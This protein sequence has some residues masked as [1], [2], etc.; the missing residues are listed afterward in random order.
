M[1]TEEHDRE[2]RQVFGDDAEQYDTAR[3]GY[4]DRL[5][6]DVLDFA[7]LPA[8]VPAVEVGAGTGKATLAFAARG[9]PV[10]CVEPDARM[11]RV[12]RSR[13]TG[14][15][16]VAV[17]VADFETWRPDRAYGLL[18]CAQAW[19][20]VDPA[21]RWARARAVLRPGGAV[22]LFWNHWDLEDLRLAER[23]T[24]VHARYGLA[25]P[26]YTI[27]DPRPRPAGRGPRARQ[28]REM[29]ADGGFAGM[30]HRLYESAHER[31]PSGLIELLASFSGYRALPAAL[32]DRL[33]RDVGRAV[34][35]DGGSAGVRVTS[36]LFLARSRA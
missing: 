20:W 33:F 29:E 6:E 36:S 22:A 35:Q 9:T 18:Y 10:T 15:P 2:R 4:P 23:L 3:P 5:V 24:A 1:A 32:R 25:V 30:E 31:S 26:P 14:L 27:L 12:L 13:C 7:A 16:H 17:E 34:E 28:W 11:A 21:V 8:S 19:H